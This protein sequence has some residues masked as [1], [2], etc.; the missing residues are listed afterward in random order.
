MR[1]GRRANGDP[2]PGQ[3]AG[4]RG[5][6]AAG[7]GVRRKASE[8]AS[9]PPDRTSPGRAS[10]AARVRGDAVET[11]TRPERGTAVEMTKCAKPKTGLAHSL[12]ISQRAARFPHS[13]S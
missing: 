8:S 2:L 5:D 4:A 10:M 1:M 3:A 7:E 11:E 13:H 12:G 9:A 6:C